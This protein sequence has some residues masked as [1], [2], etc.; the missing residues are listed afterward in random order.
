V[1]AIIDSE[2]NRLA[3]GFRNALWQRTGGHPLF[4]IELLRAMQ[5]RG[6]L[7]GGD[8]GYWREGPAL[9]WQVLPARVEAVITVR[10]LM[11]ALVAE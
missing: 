2:P 10:F 7:V 3:E 4:T 6:D 1:D 9:D 5:E 8:D 11:A